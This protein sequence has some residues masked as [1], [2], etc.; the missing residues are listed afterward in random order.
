MKD[1]IEDDDDDDDEDELT[2]AKDGPVHPDM[3]KTMQ[4]EL[5]VNK[6]GAVWIL[7]DKPLPG[8]LL[9]V[10]YD[11]P[12][13]IVALC[14]EDGKILPLGIKVNKQ[15]RKCLIKAKKV[16]VMLVQENDLEDMYL[17]PIVIRR[18]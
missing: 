4:A 6:K 16:Y 7:H 18:I 14:M 17:V 10:E 15:M 9:W 5:V 1:Y 11:V 8:V 12:E 2:P 3:R 13:D